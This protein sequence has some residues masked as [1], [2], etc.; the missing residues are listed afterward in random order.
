M[1]IR[2]GLEKRFGAH[3]VQKRNNPLHPEQELLFVFLELQTPVTLV[4]TCGLSGYEMPVSGKWEGREYNEI[5]FCL[6]AYWDFEDHSNPNSGWIFDWIFRLE[7]FVREKQTWFGPGHTIAAGNPPVSISPLMKQD[8]FIFLDPMFTADA[9][10]PIETGSKKIHFLAIVPI[11]GDEMDYKVGK[12]TYKLIKKLTRYKID[13]RLDDYRPTVLK[14]R[15]RF[16]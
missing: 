3:R 10:Q 14:T 4:M 5:F 8:H 1:E 11:F 15:M 7:S 2:E 12:G 16:F 6:P 13:E 9:L